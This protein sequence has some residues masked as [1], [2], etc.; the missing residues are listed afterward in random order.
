VEKIN[1]SVIE[2]FTSKLKALGLSTYAARTYLALLSHPYASAVF[3]C[4]ETSIPD[5]KIYYAL[6]ELSKKGIIVVQRGTPN[7]YKPIHPKEAI[8]NLKQQLMEDLNQKITRQRVLRIL[9]HQF[10]KAL[11]AEKKSN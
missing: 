1:Q 7:I 5:S 4:N 3:L 8:N 10:S 2:S 11:K 6:N 9:F